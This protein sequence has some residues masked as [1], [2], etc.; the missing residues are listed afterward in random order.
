MPTPSELDPATLKRQLAELET[1]A[2]RLEI[3]RA[4]VAKS[5]ARL[6]RRG[7]YL[8]L[9]SWF[10]APV[11]SFAAYP[12]VVFATG[13]LAIGVFVFVVAEP[14]L[15]FLVTS[16]GWL[17]DRPRCGGWPCWRRCSIVLPMSC[18]RRRLRKPKPNSKSR[19]L[20]STKR[21]PRLRSSIAGSPFYT[22]SVANWRRATSCSERCSCSA[23][24]RRCAA[25]YGKT[26]SSRS[27][28]RSGPTCSGRK[29]AK[30]V[31]RIRQQVRAA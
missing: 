15:Q 27:V 12:L 21:S 2:A 11:A 28:A 23:I 4:P 25:A 8:R 29:L 30:Y 20:V 24:G 26:L 10:R 19:L 1:E 3:D 16:D 22:S 13:P 18:C 31:D 5:V 9:A 6:R 7:R 17:P 14:P